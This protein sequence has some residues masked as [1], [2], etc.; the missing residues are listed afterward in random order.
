MRHFRRL[1]A[2]RRIG[3]M[4]E[5]PDFLCALV[6]KNLLLRDSVVQTLCFRGDFHRRATTCAGAGHS[7]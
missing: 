5:S 2:D 7:P 4:P 3:R 6:A 1:D